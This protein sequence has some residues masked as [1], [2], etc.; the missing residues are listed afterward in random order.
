[1]AEKERR[2]RMKHWTEGSVRDFLYSIASD[3]IDQLQRQMDELPMSQNELAEKLG[4]SEG[5]VS[6][7]LNKPSNLKLEKIIEYTRALGLKVAIVTYNDRDP[8]NLQG[9]VPAGIFT[10]CWEKANKP[11]DYRA[12]QTQSNP[13]YYLAEPHTA[14]HG[15][16]AY[17]G[18]EIK[19]EQTE[20]TTTDILET[21]MRLV[22]RAKA[23]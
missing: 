23:A 10:K 16:I 20:G 9:P 1:M 14:R 17:K 22:A 12:F 15:E 13:V 21:E 8:K 3:F 4:V 5:R 6:Q 18:T 7:I 2:S 19:G 11:T